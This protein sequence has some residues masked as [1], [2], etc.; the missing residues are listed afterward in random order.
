[1]VACPANLTNISYGSFVSNHSGLLTYVSQ[2]LSTFLGYSTQQI[3]GQRV[4]FFFPANQRENFIKKHEEDFAKP[5]EQ[6]QTN[7]LLQGDGCIIPVT[8]HSVLLNGGA[9]GLKLHTVL[10]AISVENG[11][12]SDK[13]SHSDFASVLQESIKPVLFTRTGGS[14]IFA[15]KA[16]CQLFGYTATEFISVPRSGI[17]FNED[18]THLK[19][20]LDKREQK[21]SLTCNLVGR[22]KT[23]EKIV[24]E[25]TSTLYHA[26]DGQEYATSIITL[27]DS[28]STELELEL[29]MNYTEE[30]FVL[31][32]R[33][34]Q[35][36][37]F[38]RQFY[39]L[40][41]QY[42]GLEVEKGKSILS[43]SPVEN[44]D[45]LAALY[46][47][48][49]AGETI[50]TELKIPLEEGQIIFQ[51]KYK[52]ATDSQGEINGVFV[53]GID[54]TD[55]KYLENLHQ[56]NERRY[57]ALV[58]N[59]SDG[60][61]ILTAEGEPKYLSPSVEKL[62]GYTLSESEK[63]SM[64]ALTHP[65]DQEKVL[66][67]WQT[68][69][70]HPG[71]PISGVTTRML[72]K[73]GTWRWMQD[74]IT[75]MLHDPAIGGI[76]D[77]FRDVTELVDAHEDLLQKQFHV[78]LAETNYREIF[79]KAN[80]GILIFNI[81]NGLL[82]D[83]NQRAL[84]LVGCTREEI[85]CS[86][87]KR[88]ESGNPNFSV[89]TALQNFRMA[90]EG[91]P[92]SF[93]WL[94]R[95]WDGIESWM[96]VS[97]KRATIAGS[98][99]VLAFFRAIDNRKAVDEEMEKLSR[100]AR[101]TNNAVVITDEFGNIQWV[102]EAFERMT[103]YSTDEVIGENPDEFLH[104]VETS[105]V[106]K[107]YMRIKKVNK[108]SFT[109]DVLNYAKSG[110]KYWV[111]MESQPRLNKYGNL[112]GF[113]ALQ[114][115]ITSERIAQSLVKHS[116]ERYRSLFDFN[117]S[118]I[119]IWDPA[120][121]K[122]LEVNNKTA[123]V[124][125]YSK[126][127]F[128]NM[129]MLN[130]RPESEYPQMRM[131]AQEFLENR[132][133]GFKGLINHYNN[134]GELMPMSFES[135]LVTYDGK[136]A[137][138]A[139]GENIEERLKLEQE[140]EHERTRRQF[141]ITA[142][143]LATQEKERKEIGE[144]LH[145]NV[146]QILAG[147]ILYLGLSRK[148]IVKDIPFMNEAEKLLHAAIFELRN[149]SHSLIPPR[150]PELSLADSLANIITLSEHS[151]IK[152][153]TRFEHIEEHAISENLKLTIY[154]IVQEQFNNILKHAKAKTIHLSVVN[155]NETVTLLIKDDGVGFSTGRKT[156]GVGLMNIKAR[157]SLY[158]SK[159]QIDSSPGNGCELKIRFK[160][161]YNPVS[162][163]QEDV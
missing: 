91:K 155:N 99:R 55:K 40:Y 143:V 137:V 13:M 1:M 2:Q 58:E 162:N 153:T 125:G 94:I 45:Q 124:Y 53:S 72:H 117:P 93:E 122:I 144:E 128:Q 73:D 83:V 113:F 47:K 78:E 38:N 88:F 92:Q 146:N 4:D 31:I 35:I 84:E 64:F 131:V 103:E 14:I 33:D 130:F 29:L 74:T 48:V 82:N 34:L 61:A 110:R 157:A 75:N 87:R 23:G 22:K 151:G 142:A 20:L 9:E 150:L 145:D 159:V 123:E 66:K 152:I 37:R 24:T 101:E 11:I 114:T 85:L 41:K 140:L 163:T 119:F 15:N 3:H 81:E 18:N 26:A 158:D 17:F 51:L 54:I 136:K 44:K 28:T 69:L 89:A 8:I 141:E 12:L 111:R 71:V 116:E 6:L 97:L 59:G 149:I 32:N 106:A 7:F 49:L 76:I 90:V 36:V 43:Y 63:L 19:N 118:C 60:V 10:P 100:I 115:D 139:M 108:R 112:V 98:D 86:P 147:A 50:N 154:R 135:T 127:E 79:E 46:Q 121:L 95:R 30:S 105:E 27:V 77:N 80:D 25:V 104:G 52:P 107:R 70:K 96:E 126:E 56:G 129:S 68:V 161:N 138:L 62:L 67:I 148:E 39:T 160:M 156:K 65:N 16:A 109:C 132:R 102:N 120:T 134:R 5:G 57:K 21:G 42:F 133:T